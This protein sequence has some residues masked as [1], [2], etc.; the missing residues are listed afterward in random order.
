M[1]IMPLLPT[2]LVSNIKFRIYTK[3]GVGVIHLCSSRRS[4]S[5]MLPSQDRETCRGPRIYGNIHCTTMA[6]RENCLYTQASTA[7]SRDVRLN[8]RDS[9]VTQ[10]VSKRLFQYI[11]PLVH[12]SDGFPFVRCKDS[13]N[14][15]L[16]A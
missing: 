5:S 12:L 1:S 7:A 10:S 13:K 16:S 6:Q 3:K 2:R 15:A 8:L 11:C 4:S 14:L 9:G